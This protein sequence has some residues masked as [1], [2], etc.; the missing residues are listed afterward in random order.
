MG[1]RSKKGR[2]VNG[3]L[4]LDKP[5]GITSN[6]ALQ[7][8]KRLFDACKAGHTGSLDPLATGVL[9]L[10]FGEATKF[11]QYLLEANKHYLAR[12]KLGVI[13]DSGDS[14]G[15]TLETREV[16]AF[17]DSTIESVLSQFR[18]D[19]MQTPSM[20]SALKVDGQPLYK[21]ARQGIEVERK[22]RPV[23][24]EQL[25]LIERSHD[26]L[27]LD[28]HC[29]KGTYVRTLAEDIG[30]EL[31]SGAHVIELRRL[32]AG[33]YKIA[34]TV[35]MEALEAMDGD[36]AAMDEQLLPLWSA[37]SDWPSV[38]LTE[39]TAAYLK[40]GQ[41]IQIANAPTN[42]WVRIFSESEN[43]AETF[44]GVGEIQEDGKVAPRRLVVHE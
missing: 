41:P 25:D 6:A 22:A 17:D 9:P 37:V 43:D 16:P 31:G 21:L 3:I 35:T 39:I 27:L 42:G 7:Q 15:K 20:F 1:R 23:R 44:I 18:G 33:P 38:R 14:D 13:T 10:C 11:S 19:I 2:K 32:G 26:E 24:I 5:A 34:S 8:V 12:V 36:F 4:L 30:L 29:T 40:Q 28:I